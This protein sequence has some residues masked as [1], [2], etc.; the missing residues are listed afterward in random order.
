MELYRWKS[1]NCSERLKENFGGSM[2][3]Q[4]Y[5]TMIIGPLSLD[6]MIDCHDAEEHLTGGAVIQSGYAASNIGART[7]VFTKLNAKDADVY[8]AF[9]NCPADIFWKPSENTTSIRNQYFT[10]DKETR[11]CRL[12]SRCDEI[13]FEDLPP[14]DSKIYHFA[15][16]TVGD[17]SNEVFEQ[18]KKRGK[19]AVDVQ[20]LLR[21]G[22]EDG[23][24]NFYDW[25]EKKKYLP[26]IDFLK[27]DAAEARI[28]TGTEDRKEAAKML[29]AWGAGEVLI[30]HNTE[31]L[32]YDGKNFYTCPIK[33]RSFV[34]RTGRGDT[35]FAGYLV[36]RL[37]SEIPEALQF[38]T[39]LVSLK[40]ET[41][42]PFC[43]TREDVEEY[44]RKFY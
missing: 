40:M 36:E 39:A 41:P 24:M 19:V 42:G 28:L 13:C 14:V 44:I 8:D 34:G 38:A 26:Y 18:A 12:I 7:A 20:C 10:E 43:G 3:K 1:F 6:I 21:R 16:L 11:E 9:Q 4:I 37:R 27:T 5:D 35:T 17:F 29:H 31:V 32:V 15:G 30:T 25:D 22:E 2:K 23:S 33:A